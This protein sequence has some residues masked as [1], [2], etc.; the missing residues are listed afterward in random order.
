MRFD[1]VPPVAQHIQRLSLEL[2]L[3]QERASEAKV[4]AEIINLVI[5]D[6]IDVASE[7]YEKNKDK[8]LE[9]SVIEISVF[10]HKKYDDTF[11]SYFFPC[12]PSPCSC[13][14]AT[15]GDHEEKEEKK[16]QAKIF[17]SV[18]LL[19]EAVRDAKKKL[20]SAQQ[21]CSLASELLR[22]VD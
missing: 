8:L 4:R 2:K 21:A 9:S 15:A 1:H 10:A 19:E 7:I 5:H 17:P 16:Q 20:E 14:T 11:V 12:L 13:S 18:E 3:A 22:I 6:E